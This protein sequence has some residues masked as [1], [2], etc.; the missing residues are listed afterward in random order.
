[1]AKVVRPVEL[2]PRVQQPVGQ[3]KEKDLDGGV[4]A[5]KESQQLKYKLF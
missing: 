3:K 4:G 1:M 2:A 5:E